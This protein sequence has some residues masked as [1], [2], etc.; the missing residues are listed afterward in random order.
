ME[1]TYIQYNNRKYI[2]PADCSFSHSNAW[3]TTE[4]RS[5]DNSGSIQNIVYLQKRGRQPHTYQ[6]G[7]SLVQA[8]QEEDLFKSISQF[9]SLIG[10]QVTFVY[11][12]MIIPDLV[13]SDGSFALDL[14]SAT[15]L[16]NLNISLNAR[17]SVV[18]TP[19]AEVLNVSID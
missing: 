2:I 15:G 10:K 13:I 1:K 12:G 16:R 18:I 9:E 6:I 3:D 11:S 14:D 5:T 7:F 4:R 17:E 19:Q 8:F